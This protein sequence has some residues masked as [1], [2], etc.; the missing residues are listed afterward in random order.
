MPFIGISGSGY[1][2]NLLASPTGF[3]MD[4]SALTGNALGRTTG[5][6]VLSGLVGNNFYGTGNLFLTNQFDSQSTGNVSGSFAYR[7]SNT[8]INKSVVLSI[9]NNPPTITSF[10]PLIGFPNSI[11]T[12]YGTNLG[13]VTGVY[14]SGNSLFS[15]G[16]ITGKYND[17][18]TFVPNGNFAGL[19]GAIVVTGTLGIASGTTPYTFYTVSGGNVKHENLLNN[20]SARP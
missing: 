6:V 19:S 9:I 1:V 7:A 16:T 17:V 2:V 18:I 13:S 10:E 11:V 5:F 8:T 14:L 12:I 3:G 15:L 20:F 4:Y